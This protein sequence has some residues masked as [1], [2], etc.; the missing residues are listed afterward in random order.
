MKEGAYSWSNR[1]FA[2]FDSTVVIIETDSA[3]TIADGMMFVNAKPGL[4]VT[5][6][7]SVL[8]EAVAEI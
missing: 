6:D 1:S 2:A 3:P 8:G 4:G 5:P 7:M